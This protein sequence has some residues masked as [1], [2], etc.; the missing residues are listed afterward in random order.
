MGKLLRVLIVLIFL[1]GIAALVLAY[2]LYDKRVLFTERLKKFEK[3]LP[4]IAATLEVEAPPERAVPGDWA[5]RDIDDITSRINNNPN[6]NSF[7]TTYRYGLEMDGETP[8]FVL[9]SKTEQEQLRKLYATDSEGNRTKDSYGEYATDGPGTLQDMLTKILKDAARQSQTL[10]ETRQQLTTLRKEYL[11]TV[12][13]LNNVKRASRADKK[14]I[15][16]KEADIIRLNDDIRNLNTRIQRL[17][18]DKDALNDEIRELKDD[19]ERRQKEIDDLKRANEILDKNNKELEKRI[20]ILEGELKIS[21]GG[22]SYK[23]GEWEKI[24]SLGDKGKVMSADNVNKFVV[25]ELSDAFATEVFGED[26]SKDLQPVELS[27][28]RP[29]FASPSGEFI[30]RI[31]LRSVIREK[32]LYVADIL[33]D[34]QQSDVEKGDVVFF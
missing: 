25:I 17:E 27:I 34:W 29:G 10:G 11:E 21:V 28:R 15:E 33:P 24:I 2:M 4:R 26:R 22:S 32:N 31:R 13:E 23:T 20:G 12:E 9:F 19:I 5:E 14:T 16:D 6:E 7:W 18:S 3:E 30:T 1:L 8:R